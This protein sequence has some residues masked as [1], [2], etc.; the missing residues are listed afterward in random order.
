NVWEW[1]SDFYRA[2]HEAAHPC[3]APANPRV[4][5]PKGSYDAAEPGGAHVA[6]RVI[7]GGSHLCSPSYCLR[8]RPAAR[9]AQQIESSMSHLGFRCILRPVDP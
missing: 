1:T 4:L 6:R 3:C 5:S 2:R 9:Q 8:Y 7:K